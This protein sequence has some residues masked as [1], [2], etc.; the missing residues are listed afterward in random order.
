[1][2]KCHRK[3]ALSFMDIHFQYTYP[4]AE[5]IIIMFKKSVILQKHITVKQDTRITFPTFSYH[6]IYNTD[7]IIM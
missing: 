5:L 6:D 3:N 2:S 1:M 4:F 7:I